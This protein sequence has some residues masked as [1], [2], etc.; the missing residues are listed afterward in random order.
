MA[1]EISSN[2][3]KIQLAVGHNKLGFSDGVTELSDS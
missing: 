1:L 3:D 2:M